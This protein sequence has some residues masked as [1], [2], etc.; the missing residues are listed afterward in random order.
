MADGDRRVDIVKEHV[1]LENAHDFTACIAPFARARYEV[2]ADEAVFDGP[3][4]VDD[5]LAE[6]RRAFPDFHFEARRVVPADDS[7]LAEGVFTGTHEGFWRGLP[8]TG[9]RVDF[10]MC[11]IFD[12]EGDDM[13]SERLYFDLGTPLRQLGVAHDPDSFKG[14]LSIVAGH[15]V[16]VTRAT[17]RTAWRTVRRRR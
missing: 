5:F 6:T 15:P 10:P 4:R 12:F 7:V 8:G 17:V 3:G 16:T 13:V 1:R 11:V 9:R 14:K 2:V